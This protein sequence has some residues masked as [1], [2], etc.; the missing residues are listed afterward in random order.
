MNEMT[1]GRVSD[2]NGLPELILAQGGEKA[3]HRTLERQS[4][5]REILDCADAIIP[6]K[7]IIGLYRHAAE[8]SGI[9]SF[10]LV[11]TGCIDL[12]EYGI[13]ADFILQAS[14]LKGAIARFQA[15]LPYYESGSAISVHF[16][17]NDCVIGYE[18]LFQSVVG[19]RH[20]GDMTLRILEAII[21]AYLGT[22]W[23]PI[24]VNLP[25]PKGAWEQDYEDV[26]EAPVSFSSDHLGF[27]LD[28]DQFENA[29]ASEQYHCPSILV[30]EDL[31]QLGHE[32]P[33]DFVGSVAR[34]LAMH[35]V[36]GKLGLDQTANRLAIGPRTLQRRLDEYGI[37]F[38]ELLERV[39]MNRACELL[40]G[41]NAT[42]ATI[43]KEL[44][45]SATSH[46]SRA[47]SRVFEVPPSHF[48]AQRA[49]TFLAM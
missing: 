5:P 4:L 17:E 42:V 30:L 7:D 24:R 36:D 33:N 3:L 26:F 15:G 1:F 46:F 40:R 34:I 12:R 18:N 49:K 27:V 48:R 37:S 25:S 10:G 20:A 29:K 9:R 11:A 21:R 14:T 32:L 31:H 28:R 2:L 6:M 8:V 47:F 16:T 23:H 38:R 19:F 41:S 35:L 13:L 43:S 44:G 45:Y 22:D 39:R